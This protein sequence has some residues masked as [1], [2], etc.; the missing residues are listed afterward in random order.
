MAVVGQ[1][2]P[3]QS[4]DRGQGALG[5]G[6]YKGSAPIGVSIRDETASSGHAEDPSPTPEILVI[7]PTSTFDIVQHLVTSADVGAHAATET[8]APPSVGAIRSWHHGPFA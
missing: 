1:G 3:G 5:S 4:F 8:Q 7:A 2:D 6:R